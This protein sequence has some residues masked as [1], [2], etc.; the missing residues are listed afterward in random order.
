[1]TIMET[2]PTWNRTKRAA[3]TENVAT[4]SSCTAG[5]LPPASTSAPSAS[6][7]R[8]RPGVGAST[9]RTR[10]WHRPGEHR[11]HCR[12]GQTWSNPY[13]DLDGNVVTAAYL[14][15]Q[16]QGPRQRPLIGRAGPRVLGPIVPRETPPRA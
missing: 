8:S 12:R 6:T 16:A 5:A 11:R 7:R 4:S 14:P 15:G 1:M 3:D 9:G 2:R 10:T 13:L